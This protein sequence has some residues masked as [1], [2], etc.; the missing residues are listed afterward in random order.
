DDRWQ[1][2]DFIEQI[3]KRMERYDEE[4][5]RWV[6]DSDLPPGQRQNLP[7]P[8]ALPRIVV[9]D[10]DL[11]PITGVAKKWVLDNV[12]GKT[13]SGKYLKNAFRTV[14]EFGA[15]AVGF[16]FG[17]KGAS[18]FGQMTG[19]NV[20]K[21]L[22]I[23]LDNVTYSVATIQSRITS[24]GRL[25]GTFTETEVK[26][27]VTVLKAGSLPAKPILEDEQTIGSILGEDSVRRGTQA[28]MIS[29]LLVIV[30]ML[31]Y[32]MFLG[33][34]ANMALIMNLM[35]VLAIMAIFRNTLTFPGMAGLLLTVGIAVDANILILER[36][37]EER[38]RGRSL[39]QA[40]AAGYQRAFSTILDANLTTLITAYILFTFGTGPIKGFAVVLSVGIIASFFT[41]LYVS[42]LVLSFLMKH[43]WITE[44]RMLQ[45]VSDPKIDFLR[46]RGG[47]ALFSVISIA[48]GFA[49]LFTR[50]AE[51]LGIDFTGGTQLVVNL[52]RSA[53]ESEM[54]ELIRGIKDEN[55]L[56][57]FPEVEIQSVIDKDRA[58]LANLYSTFSIRTRSVTRPDQ[59]GASTIEENSTAQ[60]MVRERIQRLLRQNQLLAPEAFTDVREDASAAFAVTAFL[61]KDHA[62]SASEVQRVLEEKNYPV[63]KVTQ[64]EDASTEV[65]AAY[66]IVSTASPKSAD[67]KTL[68]GGDLRDNLW[69]ILTDYDAFKLSEPFSRV[70]SISSRVAQDMQGKVF[71]AMMIA[72]GAI[73]F[74]ISLRFRF[75]FG[76]AAIVALVHDIFF[77]LGMLCIADSFLG[78]MFNLKIN[79]PVVAALLTVV[80][81]SLNDTIVIFDRVRENLT[82]KKRGINYLDLVNQS[83]NQTLGR[84]LLTSFTTFLVVLILFTWGGE[85]LH[86]FAFA[87]CIGVVVGTYSSIYVASP[88]LI[89]LHH[90]SERRRERML[91]EEAAK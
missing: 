22:A 53:T 47:A 50:G 36:I 76:L 25:T 33:L 40:V 30:F 79:L 37:R 78:T 17:G 4:Y 14:D 68:N 51:N 56:P 77:T 1:V 34:I 8:R 46:L 3:E 90:R 5:V 64:L 69:T 89:Y 20:N 18:E 13:V 74:Y 83:I 80:G 7:K 27:I 88:T 59:A 16:E 10:R 35:L 55:G 72:F 62:V 52:Q 81:Y 9:E 58:R 44:V 85:A 70:D 60:S 45:L 32:Y 15:P 71:I 39:N 66:R 28:M 23:V 31:V 11:D 87:L 12:E 57:L 43:N 24:S 61:K 6:E 26:S 19:D 2:A 49:F 65:Y 75:N 73:I 67:G 48:I 91:A 21:S 54:R 84:T 38:H 82:G 63:E 42:R 41:A 29:F 86:G